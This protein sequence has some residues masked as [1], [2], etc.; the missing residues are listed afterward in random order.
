MNLNYAIENYILDSIWYNL[1]HDSKLL[2]II[3]NYI[4]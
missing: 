1:K 4:I 2:D 3:M